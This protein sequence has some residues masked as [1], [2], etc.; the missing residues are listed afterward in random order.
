M[1]IKFITHVE[2]EVVIRPEMYTMEM[3]PNVQGT[4]SYTGVKKDISV[5]RI[6]SRIRNRNNKHEAENDS[7]Y[8]L[9]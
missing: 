2:D 9:V 1:T 4:I 6:R 8:A 5:V 7:A 3:L